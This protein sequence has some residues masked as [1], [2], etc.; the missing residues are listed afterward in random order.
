MA[1]G[2]SK[3]IDRYEKDFESMQ[4]FWGDLHKEHQ[5]D[6]EFLW[7][8]KQWDSETQ[9]ARNASNTSD[10]STSPLPP[11]PT[12]VFNILLPF[13]VKVVNGVKKMKPTLRVIP[14]DSQDDVDLAEVRRGIIIASRRTAE[15]CRPG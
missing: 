12:E 10:A 15:P 4:K 8:N 3:I 1:K 7:M 11:R 5:K 9:A 6:T 14:V 2:D 13:V